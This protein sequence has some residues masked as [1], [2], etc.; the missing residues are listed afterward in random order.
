MVRCCIFSQHMRGR[1]LRGN[2][3]CDSF[4]AIPI[5]GLGLRSF[6]RLYP[7]PSLGFVYIDFRQRKG[8]VVE[9]LAYAVA[10]NREPSSR[11]HGKSMGFCT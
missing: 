4:K 1:L 7:T 11:T 6:E 8:E 10:L 9:K 2:L 3:N 5:C